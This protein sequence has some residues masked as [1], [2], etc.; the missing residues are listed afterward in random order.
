MGDIEDGRHWGEGEKG[1]LWEYF[2]GRFV[3]G[4]N[5]AAQQTGRR[6]RF[7]P[8]S[9]EAMKK[10]HEAMGARAAA[11][12][13]RKKGL[14]QRRG[15]RI[16]AMTAVLHPTPIRLLDADAVMTAAENISSDSELLQDLKDPGKMD[17]E[18]PPTTVSIP[19]APKPSSRQVHLAGP[20]SPGLSPIDELPTPSGY[21]AKPGP[22]S[23]LQLSNRDFSPDLKF[24]DC[25]SQPMPSPLG[26]LV[27]IN[28]FLCDGDV[29]RT[30]GWHNEVSKIEQYVSWLRNVVP[31]TS[32]KQGKT[33]KWEGILAEVEG[34]LEI[35]RI[36]GRGRFEEIKALGGPSEMAK[37]DLQAKQRA[38]E[39]VALGVPEYIPRSKR[40]LGVLPL[41]KDRQIIHREPGTVFHEL[42][43][44]S[45]ESSLTK[46]LPPFSRPRFWWRMNARL[47]CGPSIAAA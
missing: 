22:V 25:G 8:I 40:R 35:H 4:W 45:E 41:T 21:L 16:L 12:K 29:N 2:E 27:G 6:R 34:K 18:T 14:V 26:T 39:G 13:R 42:H 33:E 28:T 31:A 23:Y 43:G 10:R 17:I 5:I 19:H 7:R 47:S 11:K 3:E 9:F 38:R 1:K 15:R 24:Q 32:N 37:L 20:T 46:L 44:A 36:C 30:P